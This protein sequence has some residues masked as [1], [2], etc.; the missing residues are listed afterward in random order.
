[1]KLISTLHARLASVGHR[2]QTARS[3]IDLQEPPEGSRLLI[4][5]DTHGQL[6]DVLWIFAEYG[7]PSQNN[8]YLFNGDVAD[9]GSHAVEIF[10]LLFSFS[11]TAPLSTP[12]YSGNFVT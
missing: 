5:G 3:V 10:A 4:V 2:G 6:A 12:S 8:I 7:L 11:A 1:M 9:R